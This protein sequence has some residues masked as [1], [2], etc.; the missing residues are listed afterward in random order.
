MKINRL[1]NLPDAFRENHTMVYGFPFAFFCYSIYLCTTLEER[2]PRQFESKFS[3]C[4]FA[5][6]LHHQKVD[7][8]YKLLL[9]L[10]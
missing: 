1:G 7:S 5:L 3:L 10:K 6:S 9:Q 4:S 8:G 2:L